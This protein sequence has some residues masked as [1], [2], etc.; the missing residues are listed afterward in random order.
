M[1]IFLK[2]SLRQLFT[3]II[4]PAMISIINLRSPSWGNQDVGGKA[5][6]KKEINLLVDFY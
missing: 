1:K 5:R 6:E 2:T 4:L 3:I